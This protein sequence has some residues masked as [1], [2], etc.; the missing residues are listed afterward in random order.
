MLPFEADVL[1]NESVE[2]SHWTKDA[3][4]ELDVLNDL[5][6]LNDSSIVQRQRQIFYHPQR[7]IVS[8]HLNKNTRA[9]G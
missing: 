2:R 4:E 9:V 5:N 6:D 8:H 3:S 7:C 1:H